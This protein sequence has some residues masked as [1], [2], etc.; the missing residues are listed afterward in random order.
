MRFLGVGDS[1]D[2][3][4][5]YLRLVEDR[6]DVKVFIGNPLCQDTLA[7]LVDR[8]TDWRAEL[9]W[10]RSA[11]TEGCILFENVGAGRGEL[12]DRLRRDG[13]NV[14]GSS[15][16]GAR[17]ENDRAYAQRILLDLGFS[18]ADTFEFSDPTTAIRFIDERPARYVL[19]TSGPDAPSFVGRHTA[20]RDVQA[21]LESGRKF[22]GS[23][24]VLMDFVEGVEMGV[25]G[26]FNG[27]DFLQPACLDWE[28]KRFF[29]GDLGEL[30]GEM[31]TVVTYSRTK[32]FFDR[33]LGRMATLLRENGYCGYINLNTIVNERGIWPLEFTCRF[34]YPG[35]AILDPLQRTKWAD[36]FR[37]ILNRS[38]LQF[39]FEPGF[40]VGIVITTPPFPYYRE[41]VDEPVGLPVLFEGDLSHDE[42]RHLHYGEVGL[43]NGA[44]VTTGTSGYALVVTGTGETLAAARDAANMLADKVII[45]NARYR[46]DIG[47]R[48]IEGQLREID[49]LGLFDNEHF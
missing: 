23:S 43:R 49:E 27:A 39:D 13:F 29:P 18:T 14:I 19:K 33:T 3:A 31:G 40:A 41:A 30:T 38:T 44:L 25:G 2:L 21:V 37:A 8:V 7:G 9:D 12:Q 26:Y 5:I 46:R 10:V 16:Y 32:S 45:P 17:L 4:A 35:C 48:L 47:S 34:G 1:A 28:H 15:A 6:H 20:G 11:G 42:R 24:F 36:L 22:V